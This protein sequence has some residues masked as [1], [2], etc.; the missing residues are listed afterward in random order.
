MAKEVDHSVAIVGMAGRFPGA[1]NVEELWRNLRDGVDSVRVFMDDELRA[2]GVS[3][4]LI[5]DPAY[6]K[7][8]AQPPDLDKFDASFFGINHREAEILD[9]QQR[10]FLETCWEALED[11]GYDPDA[12]QETVTGVF[13]GQTTSTYLLFNLMPNAAL[14]G[15]MDPLQL[16]VGNAG[17]SLATRVSYKL[18]LKGPSYTVQSACSTSAVAVHTACQS[19]LNGECDLALAGGV[20]INV[21]LLTGYRAAEG[22]VFAKSGK[23]RAFDAGAEGILFGGGA[24]V[25]VLKRAEDA[26]RDRDNVHALVLGSAVNN[27]GALKVGYTAPSVDGQAEVIAEAWSAAGVEMASAS[28]IE[29]H[30][31]GTRLGDPIE[32]QALTKAFRAETERTQ[33]I[34]MGSVK[35]NVGHLDVAAGIA[36]L[37]KTVLA[38]K[39]RQVPP[40]L[41][42]SEPNPEI[43]FA[44]SPVFVNTALRCWEGTQR[45]AGVSS[46]GFGGTNV[47]LVLEE[48]PEVPTTLSQ[49]ERYLL[50][51][52]AR[53]EAALEAACQRLADWLEDHP[54][55]DLADVEYTLRV[56][57]RSFEHRRVVECRTREEAI[58]SLRAFPGSAGILP[59][60]TP[61][62]DAGRMPALPGG[63]RISLPTYPFER[64]RYWIDAPGVAVPEEN[65]AAAME[66]TPSAVLALAVGAVQTFHPRPSLFNPYEPSRDE[67]EETVCRIWQ[68]VL[69][70]EPVGV[71][72]D[73]FQLGGHSLLATQVLSRVRD[74]FEVDFPLQ[75]LFSFPT[76]AELAEAIRFL[77]EQGAEE[78]GE[79][80]ARIPRS[81]LRETGGPYPLSFPQERLWFLDQFDPGTPAFNIPAVV[82][83]Q[84]KL[85]VPV[86]RWSL[87]QVVARHE[88]LRTRF[89]ALGEVGVQ[90]VLPPFSVP[91]PV[92]DLSGLPAA[93]R[94]SEEQR[95]ALAEANHSFP[96]ASGPLLRTLLVRSGPDEHVLIL[97]VHHIVSDGWSMGV[98]QTDLA[99]FYR[100]AL[101]KEPPALPELPIQYG[102]FADWQR[103]R[104][105]GETLDRQI[106]YW[107]PRL[108]GV[109]HLDLRGDRPRPPIQSFRGGYEDFRLSP[110][111][112]RDLEEVARLEG[113]SLYMVLLAAFQVLLGRHTGQDDFAVGTY[114]ANRNRAEVEGLIG[115]FINALPL[116]ADLSGEPSFRELLRR[117]RQTAL[118]DYAHQD[119]PFE[120]LLE[121]LRPERDLSRGAIVQVLFNLLNLPAVHEDLPGLTLSGSGVRNDRA[122]FDLTLWMAD[123]PA[124][125]VGWLEYNADLFDRETARRMAG[126]LQR[127]LAGLAEDPDRR[128]SDLPLLSGDERRQVLADWALRPGGYDWELCFHDLFEQQAAASPEA[129]AVVA[130]GAAS[131]RN[132]R[133][134]YRELDERSNRLAR[135]LRKLGVGPEV[136][137]GICLHKS[138]DLPVAVLAVLKAGG[139][140]VP[141]DATYA[142]DRLIWMLES[143]G[144]AVLLVEEETAG[145]IPQ[146]AE[147]T[148]GAAVIRVD[149]DWPSVAEESAERLDR[150]E[151]GV[152]P[153]NLAYV[154]FTSGSTGRPKGVMIPH[155]SLVNAYLAWEEDYGLRGLTSH[156]QMASFSFDVFTGDLARALASGGKLVLVP[157]GVLLE[158]A[159][160][161]ELARAEACDYLEFV[162]A[163]VRGVIGH[164]EQTGSRLEAARLVVVGSDAWYM[165]EAAALARLLP[166][167][168]RLFNSYGITESTID[169]TLF[170]LRPEV[171]TG[172]VAAAMVPIGRP[173]VN[174]EVYLLDRDLEPVPVGMPGELFLGGAGVGRGY[175]GRPN[176]TAERFVP[177]PFSPEPGARLYRSGDLARWLPAGDLDFVGRADQQVKVRGFR[178]E[179]GEIEAALGE[180]PAVREAVVL[181]REAGPG[182]RRLVAYVV[183][184]EGQGQE[185]GDLIEALHAHLRVRLPNYMVPS[186]FV[187]L[188]AFPL[189]PN[190]KVDRRGLP[191]PDW[192]R[193]SSDAGFVAPR[194][195]IEQLVANIWAGILKVERVGVFDSFFDLG[196]HSLMATQVIARIHEVFE[197]ELPLRTL[198]EAPLLAEQA[199]VIEEALIEKLAAEP[200]PQEP[201]AAVP[202]GSSVEARA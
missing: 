84:G 127:L 155:R 109:P 82:R 111:L 137:V 195:D 193:A 175:L 32:V 35:T 145:R 164:L 78:A 29:A 86:L 148:A 169:N 150:G 90:E 200:L 8:A 79:E 2:L 93:A 57:R 122:N 21:H 6:V 91:M 69:G 50:P 119:L 19:L 94:Q 124:G 114:I 51:V 146:P 45:R 166:P 20:S 25:V 121:E 185:E 196:G 142:S 7:A 199:L 98:L 3:P 178:I 161:V 42:F 101:S 58:E 92:A 104:F 10:V 179:P 77:Q 115:F 157:R 151:T 12:L 183:P 44:A 129:E 143:A 173:Y 62:K 172:L 56:G 68:E 15:G 133:M 128:I 80:M 182:D 184:Q 187:V 167:G 87:D 108:A 55:L 106:A 123:A 24:G 72:D 63:K 194:N 112:V 60:H 13:G 156:L 76:A 102:D 96:I 95:L 134:T 105:T 144:A 41:H 138:V 26:L 180:H 38:L 46:F 116:R 18:N 43:D 37:I 14:L 186:A 131:G 65:P 190:G 158:P 147:N 132:G 174:N 110:D 71:H 188:E 53:S 177:H 74:A 103:H 22:S 192:S 28:Y 162:P 52:S 191:A 23:C 125:M 181:A 176:L 33:R 189:T 163:M 198:F 34:P 97:I 139:G 66:E 85:D 136:R 9:P 107:R 36:G 159:K 49:R 5:A 88:T 197:V 81:P 27:D 140:Y 31:T 135:R 67:C 73:F 120:K 165:G 100:A 152:G 40:S 61:R 99:R 154:I 89:R 70:V 160:L 201:L 11:A 30:G 117:S 48:A 47:H 16:L 149:A 118:D 126:Q 1:R 17:D 113:A 170:E 54:E 171:D 39:H 64:R 141:L 4:A 168:T 130:P 153:H 75:H 83:L 59:A 202:A